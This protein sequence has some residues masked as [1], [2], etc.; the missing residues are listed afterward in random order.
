MKR[1]LKELGQRLLFLPLY[2]LAHLHDLISRRNVPAKIGSASNS[3][4]ANIKNF[5]NLLFSANPILL[6]LNTSS[7]L[8]GTL[9]TIPDTASQTET[10]SSRRKETYLL[11]SDAMRVEMRGPREGRVAGKR[12]IA[13]L[14]VSASREGVSDEVKACVYRSVWAE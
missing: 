3:P 10:E 6:S 2:R 13:Y 14:R 11:T 5:I 8:P 7:L 12:D 9:L 4:P 1:D